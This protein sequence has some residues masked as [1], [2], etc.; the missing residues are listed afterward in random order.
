MVTGKKTSLPL[1]FS[2]LCHDI[3]NSW[4][5]PGKVRGNGKFTVSFNMLFFAVSLTAADK[6]KEIRIS[7]K[8]CDNTLLCLGWSLFIFRDNFCYYD[9][10]VMQD[11]LMTQRMNLCHCSSIA[12]TTASQTW[13]NVWHIEVLDASRSVPLFIL[14][15][16][17]FL[18]SLSYIKSLL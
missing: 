15:F 16:T 8:H 9:S 12:D 5:K 13:Y 1:C 10:R 3:I 2:E 7:P 11:I 14:L 18:I 17:L 4:I 6:S